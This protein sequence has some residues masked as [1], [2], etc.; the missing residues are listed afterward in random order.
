MLSDKYRPKNQLDCNHA[1]ALRDYEAAHK[2]WMNTSVFTEAGAIAKANKE[3]C[4]IAY[5]AALEAKRGPQ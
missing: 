5:E 2:I 1:N 3:R 4:R